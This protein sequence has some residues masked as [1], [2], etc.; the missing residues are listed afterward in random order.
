MRRM[1]T[2]W[3]FPGIVSGTVPAVSFGAVSGG[4]SRATGIVADWR[5]PVVYFAGTVAQM[6]PSAGLDVGVAAIAASGTAGAYWA[7]T[8]DGVLSSGIAGGSF[9]SVATLPLGMY[10]NVTIQNNSPYSLSSV[11]GNVYTS[12]ATLF[13]TFGTVA[14]NLVYNT[15]NALFYSFLPVS[16]KIGNIN[17][18]GVTGVIALPASI[19]AA[20]ALATPITAD[21]TIAIGGQS[22]FALSGAAAYALDPAT[23][24][25]ML[26]VGSGRAIV[27]NATSTINTDAWAQGQ[28]LTSGVANLAAV[29]WLPNGTQ[30]LAS[31]PAS[32]VVQVFQYAAS[33]L[34]LVQ[35]LTV[36]GA[37]ALAVLPSNTDALVCR[38]TSN[39]VL[40]LYV[41]GASWTASGTALSLTAPNAIATLGSGAAA[42]G[43]A[44]GVALLTQ[45]AGVWAIT[46]TG[47][48]NILPTA[49]TTDLFGNVLLAGSGGAFAVIASGNVSTLLSSGVL[50][51]GGAPTAAAWSQ[52]RWFLATPAVSG[53]YVLGLSAPNTWTQQASGLTVSGTPAGIAIGGTTV[54]TG[55]MAGGTPLFC[56]SGAP[57]ALVPVQQGFVGVWNG[58]VWATGSL[59]AGVIPSAIG[60]DTSGNV[61]VACVNNTTYSF[62]T[63]AALLSSGTVAPYTGQLVNIPLG[64]SYLFVS[65]GSL[66]ASTSL[67]GAVAQLR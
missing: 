48:T 3:F 38:S 29:A 63:A 67:A 1:T 55:S 18:S 53:V 52:G 39:Q 27:W 49:M 22:N 35:T 61:N 17:S 2:G 5:L 59:G 28:V 36:S 11:S 57:Y 32:G 9:T 58:S 44:S 31:D 23:G 37:G 15:A 19:S 42:V 60:Y 8:R 54:F 34:S 6:L 41:S 45:T 62:S 14:T 51:G 10:S 33:V 21:T 7:L 25:Q 46:A 50:S 47:T 43:Y 26:G 20:T 65:G 30:A 16:Q 4:V 13:S 40:P 56:L 64:L 66:Y 24:T 12:G